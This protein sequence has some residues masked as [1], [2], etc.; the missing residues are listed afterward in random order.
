MKLDN[1]QLTRPYKFKVERKNKKGV[2]K[3]NESEVKIEFGTW[4]KNV[5]KFKKIMKGGK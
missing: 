5:N 4:D 1:W 2:H 3:E